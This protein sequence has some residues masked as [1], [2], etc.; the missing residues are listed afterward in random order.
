MEF[1]GEEKELML[2]VVRGIAE[3]H[4]LKIRGNIASLPVLALI[5]SGASHNFLSED[6]VTKLGMKGEKN[7]AFWVRL[8]DGTRRQTA[9]F[10][11]AVN[12]SMGGV[13]LIA[14][15]TFFRWEE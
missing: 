14:D 5:D 2:H 1:G 10:C 12:L 6:V 4:T 3:P 7:K 9:G 8:G 11:K 15:F 13:N